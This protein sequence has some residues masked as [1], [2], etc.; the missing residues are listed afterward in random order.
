[1]AD[2]M[3]QLTL[4][5]D[6]HTSRQ[7]TKVSL[8]VKTKK[9]LSHTHRGRKAGKRLYVWDFWGNLSGFLPGTKKKIPKKI[10]CVCVYVKALPNPVQVLN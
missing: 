10:M 5:S 6:C 3:A 4:K 2:N 7:L 9:P 8:N 1:M